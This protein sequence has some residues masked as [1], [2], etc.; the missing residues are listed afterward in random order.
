MIT[1]SAV[2]VAGPPGRSPN[3]AARRKRAMRVNDDP[4][5]ET[6]CDAQSSPKGYV[7]RSLR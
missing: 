6:A 7:A 3:L 1:L 2:A 5:S 4:N